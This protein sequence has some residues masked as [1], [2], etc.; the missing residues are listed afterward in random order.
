MP[1]EFYSLHAA[2]EA[3]E[4]ALIVWNRVDSGD[5]QRLD[6]IALLTY[7]QR[8]PR[9]LVGWGV[10]EG[11]DLGVGSL[12]LVDAALGFLVLLQH[13]ALQI[14]RHVFAISSPSFLPDGR[15]PDAPALDLEAE[16]LTFS[17]V[18][19]IRQCA[20]RLEARISHAREH[21]GH[22]D[23]IEVLLVDHDV[24]ACATGSPA[25]FVDPIALSTLVGTARVLAAHA[26]GGATD[27]AD[28]DP[29][30]QV[31][32]RPS[33]PSPA[34]RIAHANQSRACAVD[35]TGEHPCARGVSVMR[36]RWRCGRE[37]PP[38]ASR[39]ARSCAP[40]RRPRSACIAG[41]G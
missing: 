8:V 31:F 39:S 37:A 23:L 21:G 35:S 3:S 34:G 10:P 16:S 26:E 20:R 33:S 4:S 29:A 32:R 41:R 22:D 1:F 14:V 12:E 25:A 18:G 15:E 30:Q 17:S 6:D 7:R 40:R 13:E 27:A 9:G 24:E 2:A 36:R 28:G 19:V 5:H 38:T 11:S